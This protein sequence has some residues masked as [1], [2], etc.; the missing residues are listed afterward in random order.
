MK[1]KR[2]LSLLLACC[3]T[4]AVLTACSGETGNDTSSGSSTAGNV[5]SEDDGIFDLDSDIFGTESED[6]ASQATPDNTTSAETT[7]KDTGSKGTT[8]KD[9]GSKGPAQTSSIREYEQVDEKDI[10]KLPQHVQKVYK[11]LPNLKTDSEKKLVIMNNAKMTESALL[12]N[13]YGITMETIVVP[14]AELSNRYVASVN[15][16]NSPD[17]LIDA[18]S[19]TYVAKKY[20]QAWDSYLN[21]SDA[22]WKDEKPVNDNFAVGGKHYMLIPKDPTN[23]GSFVT[24]ILYNADVIKNAGLKTPDELLKENKWDWDAFINIAEKTTNVSNKKYGVWM[25]NGPQM[26]VNTTGN[27]YINFEKGKAKNMVK[28]APLARAMQAYSDLVAKKAIYSGGNPELLVGRGD[29]AMAV[30]TIGGVMAVKDKVL[31]GTCGFT[32]LPKDPQADAIY[33]PYM[34]NG[35]YLAKG[36]KHPNNAVAFMTCY[37][38]EHDGEYNYEQNKYLLNL[39]DPQAYPVEILDK[40]IEIGKVAKGVMHTWDMFNGETAVTISGVGSALSAGEPWSKVSAEIA[41][42]LDAGIKAFYGG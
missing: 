28:S 38:Y 21:L 16:N 8:S 5:E 36:A 18:Y 23:A 29:V 22:M 19:Y 17:I 1:T 31:K 32:A 13:K 37:H 34:A 40:T 4:I 26:F 7:S 15:A 24:Y 25:Y 33:M 11:K 10:S 35:F 12:G 2:I 42:V 27:D 9:T 14:W 39:N 41:P 3:L 20:V 6:T 30:T